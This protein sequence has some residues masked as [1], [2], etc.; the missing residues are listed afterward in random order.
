MAHDGVDLEAPVTDGTTRRAW[1]GAAAG[2][3]AL[4]ASG[5]FLPDWLEEAEARD[6][7]YGGRTPLLFSHSAGR[8]AR[9]P[10]SPRPATRPGNTAPPAR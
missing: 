6:G 5:L 1:L 2:G 4:A 9:R 10:R 8:A 3:F 7:A